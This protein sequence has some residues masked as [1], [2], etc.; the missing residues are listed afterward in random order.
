VGGG[1]TN[2]A[3]ALSSVVSGGSYNR[4]EIAATGSTNANSV[5]MRASGGYR[6]STGSHTTGSFLAVGGGSWT[7]MSDRNAKENIGPMAQDFRAAFSLAEIETGIT[8]AWMPTAWRWR[9]SKGSMR[10]WKAE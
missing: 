8:Q 1:Y 5:T 10:R 6:M 7:S 3:A 2:L 9:P 4:V